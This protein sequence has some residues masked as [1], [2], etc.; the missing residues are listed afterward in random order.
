MGL[1]KQKRA[2]L[3]RVNA[4]RAMFDAEKA[5]SEYRKENMYGKKEDQDTSEQ[6]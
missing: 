4:K 2:E 6:K 1:K 3:Q 5:Q